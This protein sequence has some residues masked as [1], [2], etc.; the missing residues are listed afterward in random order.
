[1][2]QLIFIVDPIC[3]WCWGFHPIIKSL[4]KNYTDRYLCDLV[5]GGLRTTGQMSWDTTSKAYLASNWDKV[6]KSTNQPFNPTLLNKTNFDYNTYPSCKAVL[7]VR[8]LWGNSDAFSYLWAIQEA[9]YKDAKDITNDKVLTSY[10]IQDKNKFLDFYTSERAE[11][12]MHHDFSKARSMGANSFPSTV[13][14]DIE[15]HMV[16]LSGYKSLEEILKV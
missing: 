1:V 6:S 5:L 14:I 12:L 11:T 4:R 9:F 8:E 13:K 15:G 10:I 2:T 7:T 3:S 16:C